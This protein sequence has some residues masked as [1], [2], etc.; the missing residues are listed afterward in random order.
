MAAAALH[1]E[2]TQ[3]NMYRALRLGRL[4]NGRKYLYASN[5]KHLTTSK[6]L[7]TTPS[8][9][10]QTR[11]NPTV[12][13]TVDD[14]P[15]A[16]CLCIYTAGRA[17]PP[18]DTVRGRKRA[19]GIALQIRNWSTKEWGQTCSNLWKG[20]RLRLL[21]DAR[22]LIVGY[23]YTRPSRPRCSLYACREALRVAKEWLPLVV[24][25]NVNITVACESN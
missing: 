14:F 11:V 12:N 6:V 5:G 21:P 13:T 9:S 22:T 7:A 19:G 23:P 18:E 25:P 15:N 16:S 20:L 10:I 3:S 8:E 2:T 24:T 1:A 17:F 4:V